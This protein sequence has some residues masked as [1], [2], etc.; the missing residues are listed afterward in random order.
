M[1][2]TQ[3]SVVAPPLP[4]TPLVILGGGGNQER[5]RFLLIPLQPWTVLHILYCCVL[6]H[7]ALDQRV[8]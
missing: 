4:H 8:V 6:A 2:S 1:P 7:G 3:S 5:H